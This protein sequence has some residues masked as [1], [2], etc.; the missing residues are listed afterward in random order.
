M[1][2]L[3]N[4]LLCAVVM[5]ALWTAIG[6]PVAARAFDRGYAWL[7]APALGWAASSVVALPLFE[8]TG[9]GRAAVLLTAGLG[10]ACALV[11]ICKH[12]R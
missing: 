3:G 5:T 8:M 2:Q 6:L 7:L 11:A 10:A 1:A 12:W 9:M 4:T